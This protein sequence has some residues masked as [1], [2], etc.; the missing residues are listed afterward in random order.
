MIIVAEGAQDVAGNPVTAN[1]IK[2]VHNGAI[3]SIT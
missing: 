2:E 3:Y 1:D